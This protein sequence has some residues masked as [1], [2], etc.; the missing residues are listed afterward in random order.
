MF[1]YEE[2]GNLE[3][4]RLTD[5][6]FERGYLFCSLF[7]FSKNQI[8]TVRQTLLKGTKVAWRLL[9]NKE[10]DEL[11]SIRLWNEVNK[12]EELLEFDF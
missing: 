4:V 11:M 8:V 3:I 2:D 7:F 1:T 10:Y 9:D 5:V 6:H 12:E